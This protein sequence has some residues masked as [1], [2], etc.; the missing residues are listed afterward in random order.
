MHKEKIIESLWEI[1]SEDHPEV[2]CDF[3]YDAKGNLDSVRVFEECTEGDIVADYS[4]AFD[5]PCAVFRDTLRKMLL[6]SE[7]FGH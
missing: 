7:E 2:T 6:A 1:Y 5:S 4:V 3:R